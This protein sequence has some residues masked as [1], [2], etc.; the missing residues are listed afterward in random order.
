MTLSAKQEEDCFVRREG[1]VKWNALESALGGRGHSL[2][3]PV[4]VGSEF[5]K[6]CTGSESEREPSGGYASG[7]FFFFN[8]IVSTA[9][10]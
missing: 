2:G 8:R 3:A 6:N 4:V 9:L 10:I 1:G 7:G 5:R